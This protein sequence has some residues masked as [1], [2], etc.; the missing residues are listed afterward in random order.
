MREGRSAPDGTAGVAGTRRVRPALFV[1]LGTLLALLV[2]AGCRGEGDPAGNGGDG[3]T[4]SDALPAATSSPASSPAHDAVFLGVGECSSFGTVSFTEVPCAGERAAA[5]V[6]ARHDG[7]VDDGPLCPATTDFVLHISRQR[8]AS[9]AAGPT[10]AA[11]APSG[12]TAAGAVIA[13]G[14]ACLRNLEPPHPGDPGA[15]GGPRTIV[16]DCVYDVGKG[17]VH[18]TACDGTG[19][20]SPQYR[21]VRAVARRAQCPAATTLYVRIG[22]GRPVGCAQPV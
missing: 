12:T 17:E 1:V 8:T 2:T 20:R 16:G 10:A 15:G 4:N 5:K 18:E 7:T 9:G 11:G 6:V 21:V 19:A 3:G 22:G 13:P 14:Y